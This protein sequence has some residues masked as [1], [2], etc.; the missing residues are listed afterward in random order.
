MLL[1]VSSTGFLMLTNTLALMLLDSHGPI[2]C[3]G[4][5]GLVIILDLFYSY[6]DISAE[7]WEPYAK[8]MATKADETP[9]D[10]QNSTLFTDSDGVVKPKKEK[11]P[12]PNSVFQ[13]EVWSERVIKTL[14]MIV[15]QSICGFVY[16]VDRHV[17][18]DEKM[19]HLVCAHHNFNVFAHV[20]LL[21]LSL[22]SSS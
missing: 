15:Y 2:W 1:F 8:Q 21:L 10:R 12:L 3:A 11:K 17:E 22:S 18:E 13:S 5:T 6:C 20:L 19:M 9:L 7:Y 16:Y 14:G 4:F